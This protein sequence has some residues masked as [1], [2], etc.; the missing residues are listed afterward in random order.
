[1][2]KLYYKNQSQ[3]DPYTSAWSIKE[4]IGIR[5]WN[6][7]WFLFFSWTPKCFRY[8]RVFLLKL[9]GAKLNWKVFIYSS[10]KIYVPWLLTMEGR[11]C[12]G[13]KSE[14]YN[15]GHVHIKDRATISQY[16][17]VCNGTHDLA[18]IRLPLMAGNILI[19][20]DVFI[21]AK[22]FIMPG[23]TINEGAVVG[24]C[25]VVTKDIEA[26]TMV[27]GNPAKCIRKR[28]LINKN[29]DYEWK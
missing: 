18:D 27:A 12:L 5:L 9:F 11:S 2:A 29:K 25:S 15:L 14:I 13:P 4:V 6:M 22:V 28:T 19:E 17:Y 23:I 21:G 16:V 3:K 1:M 10:A 20:S 26:W 7:V 8:W 24:A